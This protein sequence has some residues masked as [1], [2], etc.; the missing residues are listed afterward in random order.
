MILCVLDAH[1]AEGTMTC[2]TYIIVIN[3][4]KMNCYFLETFNDTAKFEV[5]L[6]LQPE[7]MEFTQDEGATT[8]LYWIKGDFF[9]TVS[10]Q[11]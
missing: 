5:S 4:E 7:T 9:P 1:Q 8:N 11:F 6:W 2:I 10:I 3:Q